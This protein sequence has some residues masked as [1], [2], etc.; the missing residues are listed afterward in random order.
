M[1]GIVELIADALGAVK[2]FF[3]FQGKRLDLKN[4]ADVKNAAILKE[5]QKAVDKTTKAVAEKD[6][7]EIRKEI[8]E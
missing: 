8:A 5:E 1:G 4:A 6:I 2:E 3:S 7:D